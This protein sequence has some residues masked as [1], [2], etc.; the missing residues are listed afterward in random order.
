[1][2][3]TSDQA[4]KIANEY[5]K[6]H[7]D[8]EVS[9]IIEGES[10]EWPKLTYGLGLD[11]WNRSWVCYIQNKKHIGLLIGSTVLLIDKENGGVSFFG[12]LDDEG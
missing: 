1:M 3:I 5:L 9:E 4:L 7:P 6:S 2:P 12:K 10:V 8:C 11:T